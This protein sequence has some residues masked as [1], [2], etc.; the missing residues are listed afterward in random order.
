MGERFALKLS[1]GNSGILCVLRDFRNEKLRA[2][3]RPNRERGVFRGA[4]MF[5]FLT[6]VYHTRPHHRTSRFHPP[7]PFNERTNGP[8]NVVIPS[9]QRES[10]D[11]RTDFT[12]A[13]N[14]VPGSLDFA[15]AALGMTTWCKPG[16]SNDYLSNSIRRAKQAT[17]RGAQRMFCVRRSA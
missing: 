5:C 15:Y 3:I 17:G 9:E 12:L 2:K 13:L 16:A 11:L 1:C 6:A 14:E 4:L 7:L 10:R 8:Q